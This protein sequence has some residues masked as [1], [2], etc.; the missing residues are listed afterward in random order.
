MLLIAILSGYLTYAS[1]VPTGDE[2]WATP[3]ILQFNDCDALSIAWQEM[4]GSHT[5][6]PNATFCCNI[7]YWKETGGSIITKC[8]NEGHILQVSWTMMG[9]SGLISES[10]LSLK[11]LEAIDLSQNSLN[12]TIPSALADLHN[13]QSLTLNNNQLSGLIP[14]TLSDLPL[15][16]LSLASNSLS[17]GFPDFAN[18][19]TCDMAGNNLCSSSSQNNCNLALNVCQDGSSD[20]S[21][22]GTPTSS[23]TTIPTSSTTA[24][25]TTSP[26]VSQES[27]EPVLFKSPK[28]QSLTTWAIIAI[29]IAC[30]TVSS[31]CLGFLFYN[32]K[33]KRE[34]RQLEEQVVKC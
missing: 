2:R 3:E 25:S 33:D 5:L 27:P 12:G 13:L 23:T 7:S 24:S 22:S 19:Q 17:G 20:P 28:S 34:G 18:I 29:V 16:T 9:L 10:L 6:A 1:P 11:Y 14:A 32:R 30:V 8:D 26:T 31:C 15:V 4:H 21:N